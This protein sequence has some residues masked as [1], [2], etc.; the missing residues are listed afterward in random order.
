MPETKRK[1]KV[2]LCHAS[3]DKPAVRGLYQ[4]LKAEGWVDP[5]LDEEKLLPGQ[6]WDLEIERAVEEADAVIVFLSSNSVSEEGYI[7]RELRFVL[8]IA[9]YKPEGTLFIIPFRL[10]ECPLPRRLKIWHYVDFFPKERE[11][12][13]YDRLLQSLRVR[14]SKKLADYSQEKVYPR[15]E[16]ESSANIQL[17]SNQSVEIILRHPGARKGE[18]IQFIHESTNLNLEEAKERIN[19]FGG[20]RF[21][22]EDRDVAEQVK[23]M[24]HANG[25]I[26]EIIDF[27]ST[28]E[29]ILILKDAGRKKIAVIKLIRQLTGLDLVEAKKIVETTGGQLISTYDPDYALAAK[30][31]FQAA[32]AKVDII[33]K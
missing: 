6:D 32:G 31:R 21:S 4:R 28:S 2:F 29:F 23:E 25:A 7:Q 22:F 33:Q 3:E 9:D 12:W 14:G 10:D 15:R 18:V 8:T 17:E 5:W 11:V 13:A 24:F 27:T 16:R 30:V 20:M 19:T 1:L 26:I